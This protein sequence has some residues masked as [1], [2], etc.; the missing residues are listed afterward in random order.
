MSAHYFPQ[1]VDYKK[2]TAMTDAAARREAVQNL[3]SLGE[4]SFG[5]RWQAAWMVAE[6]M[7][8]ELPAAMAIWSL[9]PTGQPW[10]PELAKGKSGKA[11]LLACLAAMRTV[12]TQDV[13]ESNQ[14]M[15]VSIGVLEELR[16]AVELLA[17][18][19]QRSLS[20]AE[21]DLIKK[22]MSSSHGSCN[23]VKSSVR[24]QPWLRKSGDD[25]D[26]SCEDH[27]AA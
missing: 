21:I 5:P 18:E 16:S 19:G 7:A 23:L 8:L 9:E 11:S 4:V 2:I 13:P 26:G 10:T 12:T 14:V 27:G 25:K 15:H 3:L 17:E 24:Q 20:D 6:S 22:V 1:E